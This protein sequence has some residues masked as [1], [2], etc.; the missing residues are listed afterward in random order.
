LVTSATC[1]FKELITSFCGGVLGVIDS[2][3]GDCDDGDATGEEDNAG[4]GLG[5][6]AGILSM[7]AGSTGA[8]GSIGSLLG[9][10]EAEGLCALPGSEVMGRSLFWRT[11]TVPEPE[12]VTASCANAANGKLGATIATSD[13]AVMKVLILF[14]IRLL[15]DIRM[16]IMN[17]HAAYRG[18]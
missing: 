1:G 13:T 5:T 15:S 9:R 7:G 4:V 12:A 8:D 14:L 17:T 3:E 11:G 18:A 6:T 10:I 2:W 16:K